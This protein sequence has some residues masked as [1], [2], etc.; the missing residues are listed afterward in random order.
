MADAAAR[1]EARR[2]RI[3]EN[4]EYRLQKISG[5]SSLEKPLEKKEIVLPKQNTH[6]VLSNQSINGIVPRES[7]VNSEWDEDPLQLE[8]QIDTDLLL[9]ES[10]NLNSLSSKSNSIHDNV[11][12]E[13][14]N[15]QGH[16]HRNLPTATHDYTENSFF[17]TEENTQKLNKTEE[18]KQSKIHTFFTNQLVYTIL[19]IIINLMMIFQLDNIYGKSIITPFFMVFFTRLYFIGVVPQS[20]KGNMLFAALVLCNIQPSILHTFQKVF[21]TINL[22]I[23]DLSLYIFSFV[24]IFNIITR[25]FIDLDDSLPETMDAPDSQVST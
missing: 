25:H 8:N 11:V 17:S 22:F 15:I 19:A 21:N 9:S 4:S 7:L 5:V 16:R 6:S 2:R 20:S 23:R 3:L 12:N 13:N 14:G 18:P 1:R 10:E 24:I